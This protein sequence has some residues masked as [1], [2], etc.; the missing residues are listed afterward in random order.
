MENGIYH[1]RF[2]SAQDSGEGLI[3]VKDGSINGGDFGYL[4]HGT[5]AS[6]DANLSA[7]L[8]VERWNQSH[9]SI[10]GSIAKFGLSLAGTEDATASRFTLRGTVVGQ[11]ALQISIEGHRLSAGS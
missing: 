3:V 8:T 11:P 7:A 5:I 9:V 1:V 4:Y 2:S 6:D 10:F